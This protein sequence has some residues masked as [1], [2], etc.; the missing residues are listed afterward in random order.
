MK[1]LY[2]ICGIGNGHIFRQ[3][4]IID[5]FVK[6]GAELTIFAYDAS[7][8]FFKKYAQNYSNVKVEKVAVPYYKGND[9]G[10]NFADSTTLPTNDQDFFKINCAAMSKAGSPDL[11]ISDYEPI[12]AQYAYAC[13]APLITIDQQ[14]KYLA[15]SFPESLNG[16]YFRDEVMRLK[17]FFPRATARIAC[18]F[19]RI[20]TEE[21]MICPPPL[22]E[23]V[24]TLKRSPKE[25]VILVYLSAQQF[26]KQP[27]NEMIDIFDSVSAE[28]HLFIPQKEKIVGKNIHC[29]P[30]NDPQ[31]DTIL[32]KCSGIIS[33]AGHGLLSEAMYLGI[34]ILALPLNLYEQQMN[35][36]VIHQNRFGLSSQKLTR[37]TV[38]QFLSQIDPFTQAISQD[39]KVLFRSNGLESILTNITKY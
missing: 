38:S 26:Q 11:V 27:L 20:E 14:S 12:S 7:Y 10:I 37:E 25:N 3:L 33:T 2:G 22:R 9:Q 21:V 5:H 36:H 18:S 4:P 15:N 29:Y 13:D 35:A 6:D 24:T 34:P 8:T 30:H 17:M 23:K 16:C 32:S 28:F 39:K 19:F 31:F 1:I